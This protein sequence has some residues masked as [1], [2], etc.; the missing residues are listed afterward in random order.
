MYQMNE[1]ELDHVQDALVR[2]VLYPFAVA[3]YD[4]QDSVSIKAVQSSDILDGISP[5]LVNET[6]AT[7][8]RSGLITWD[9]HRIG[10]I[11]LSEL[12]FKKFLLVRDGFFDA[13]QNS[14]LRSEILAIDPADLQRSEVYHRMKKSCLGLRALPGQPCPVT[15][16]WQARRLNSAC[17]LIGENETI[18]FPAYD[19]QARRVIWYLL[20]G[21][22]Q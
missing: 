4:G 5:D 7:A 16:R 12:G 8:Q 9:E 11:R 14:L 18:P 3:D 22:G 1:C 20:A 19:D 13:H 17:L 6:L 10:A 21:S 15:G 2:A